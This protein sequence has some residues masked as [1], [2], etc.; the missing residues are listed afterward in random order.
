MHEVTIRIKTDNDTL[1]DDLVHSWLHDKNVRIIANGH[2]PSIVDLT[3]VKER[4]L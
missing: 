2:Q 3:Y 1:I 4:E